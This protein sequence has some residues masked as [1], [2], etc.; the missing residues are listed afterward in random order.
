[1]S[2]AQ[3]ASVASV[4]LGVVLFFV[5]VRRPTPAAHPTASK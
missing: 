1:M 2:N 4:L 5:F 3:A